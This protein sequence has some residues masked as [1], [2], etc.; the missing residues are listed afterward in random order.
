MPAAM[1]WN[2]HF[3]PLLSSDCH[4]Y[5]FQVIPFVLPY[6]GEEEYLNTKVCAL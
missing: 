2:V 1:L 3:I 6:V 5:S 4:A